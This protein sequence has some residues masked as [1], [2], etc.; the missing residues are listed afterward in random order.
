[1]VSFF[2]N[3]DVRGRTSHIRTQM[4]DETRLFRDRVQI[5]VEAIE[6]SILTGRPLRVQD[7]LYMRWFQL[8][9]TSRHPLAAPQG[10]CSSRANYVAWLDFFAQLN[11]CFNTPEG[12]FGPKHTRR[13]KEATQDVVDGFSAFAELVKKYPH[14][15]FL[16][17]CVPSLPRALQTKTGAAL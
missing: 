12:S 3:I 8:Y 14:Y 11:A 1:M 17:S 7:V 5:A 15:Q 10:E 16:W 6:F 9:C 2:S 13:H 4:G